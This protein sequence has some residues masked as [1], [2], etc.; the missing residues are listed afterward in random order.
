MC[1]TGIYTLVQAAPYVAT[2]AI[3]PDDMIAVEEQHVS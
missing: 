2:E 1:R 3:L